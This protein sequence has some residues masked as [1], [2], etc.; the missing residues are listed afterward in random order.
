MNIMA[1]SVAQ[2]DTKKLFEIFDKMAEAIWNEAEKIKVPMSFAIC[3]A[4]GYLQYFRRMPDAEL[5]GISLAQ[6][7]AYTAVFLKM[8]S[9]ELAPLALPD[10][11]LFGINVNDPRLVVFGGGIPLKKN[12]VIVGAVGVS[13]GTVA[14][15]IQVAG[16]AVEVFEKLAL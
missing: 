13:G 1:S 6:N 3:D 8:T 11:E 16:K 9:E 15:D 10:G 7:K 2:S 14:E 5:I 4:G 12:G